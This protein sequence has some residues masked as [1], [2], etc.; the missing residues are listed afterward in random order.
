MSEAVVADHAAR[1]RQ[2]IL[3]AELSGAQMARLL[4]QVQTV[5]FLAGD[6][7][8]EKDTAAKFLYLIDSG[9]LQVTSAAGRVTT[10]TAPRCGEEAAADLPN[11]L[12]RVAATT[13]GKAL[14]I[15]REALTE[16]ATSAPTLRSQASLSLMSQ[17]GG[18]PLLKNAVAKKKPAKPIAAREIVG[19]VGVI[20]APPLIYFL[21]SA[22]GLA[23]E[24]SLFLAILSATVLMWLFSLA[25]EF[26]PPL[27]A[28]AAV[29][30]VG[31]VPA[32]VALAG[33]S[34]RTL[35]ILLGVYALAAVMSSSGLSYR[36]ML[37]LL[38]RL[39]DTPFWHQTAL[40]LSGYILSP[41]MP[42]GNARLTLVL[43][44]YRDMIDGLNLPPQSRDATALMAAT[45]SGAMLFSPMLLTSKSSNLTV[46]GMLPTQ[47]QDEFQG[48][49]WIAA[50]GVAALTV[51][52]MHLLFSRMIFGSGAKVALPKDKLAR[53]LAL[54]G[55]IS[56]PEKAALIGFLF[57]LIGAGTTN[58]H[59]I[60]PAWLAAFLLAGLLLM[61]LISKKDFQTK[62]DWPMIFFLL[63]LDGLSRA[64]TYLGLDL[65]LANAAG[66]TFDFIGGK[67]VLFIPVALAVTLLLRIVLPITAGMVV[68][69]VILLPI[70][71]AQF[72]NPWV[73]VFLTAMF[74]DI[75]FAP[76]QSSQYLQ[77]TS[78]GYGRYYSQRDFLSYNY[79]MNFSRVLAAY[80]SIPYWQWLG[81]A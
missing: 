4:G 50:A 11:Y 75:W 62:I 14:R 77:V 73:V 7:L 36:F 78:S 9:E 6:A 47:L 29:L 80:L 22:G 40:L 72:I 34:S 45:F 21:G 23:V 35:T 67:L 76:Y 19:W 12:Y 3:F 69:A 55:P 61:G 32:D 31:L 20:A 52:A 66:N 68:A 27:V 59:Q 57:F 8:C 41:I 37:W 42:S 13:A 46:F 25:D 5:D 70:A 53:Q 64:I 16:L 51:T 18:E 15:P 39:P 49:F 1:L 74:S 58:L 56:R 48:L 24:A 28:I 63:S 10:L 81:L 30:I 71:Q 2:D 44:F 38:I 17:L 65:A 79:W 54:L 33:F 60:S 43:P 26:V